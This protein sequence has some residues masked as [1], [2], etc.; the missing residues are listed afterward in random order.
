VE[1]MN[2]ACYGSMRSPGDVG[3]SV[4]HKTDT[5]GHSVRTGRTLF[6]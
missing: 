6:F 4:T 2:W 3:Q 5:K 1:E